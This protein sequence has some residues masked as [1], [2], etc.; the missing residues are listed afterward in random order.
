MQPRIQARRAPAARRACPAR[1]GGR[2]RCATTRSAC[3]M[4][5]SRCAM[6]SVVRPRI[7]SSSASCTARSRLAVERRGGLVE[8]QDRRVLVDRAGDRQPLALAARQLAAVVADRGVDALRQ[9]LDEVEQVGAAQR[10]RARACRRSA[11]PSATLAA[12]LSLNST[13]SWLTSANWRRS[14]ATS[15]SRSGTPSSRMLARRGLDEARQQVDQ[16]RLAGARGA[17]Q[18]HRL[19]GLRWCSD[20]PSSAGAWSAAVAQRHA[21]SSMRP[22]RSS[23]AVRAAALGDAVFDQVDAALERRQ[24]AQ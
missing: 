10:R 22:A 2:R 18:R 11:S 19:A 4:V 23:H 13:T 15:Q 8:D 14:A 20:K 12:T 3:S 5:D 9:R 7:S 24:A 17:D 1:R 21:R 16:R 6:T